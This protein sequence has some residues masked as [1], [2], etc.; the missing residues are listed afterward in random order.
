LSTKVTPEDEITE[1][2][3]V[4]VHITAPHT[5]S[6]LPRAERSQQRVLADDYRPRVK[7]CAWILPDLH[8]S[9]YYTH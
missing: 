6:S 1:N 5:M 4:I 8:L 3:L 7:W 2:T 9:L